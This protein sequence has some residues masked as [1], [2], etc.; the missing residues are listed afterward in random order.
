LNLEIN[1]DKSA[2]QTYLQQFGF[3]PTLIE[4][5]DE[6]ERFYLAQGTPFDSKN[7]LGH[8]RSFLENVQKESMPTI[9]SKF[10]GDL[11][12]DWGGGLAY[13]AQNGVLSKAEEQ[14]AVGLYRLISD[15][16]VHPLIAQQEYVRLSRNMVVEYALLY[17]T[18]IQ[19]LGL[20]IKPGV[21]G[22]GQNA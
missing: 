20:T 13:L 17:L 7:S 6:A 8:L 3:S 2:V 1:Q 5:L 14:F 16:G 4:T 12:L 22:A 10:G 15:E 18:K 9:H 19:K 11:C 21:Q